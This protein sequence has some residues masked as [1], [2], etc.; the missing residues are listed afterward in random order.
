MA[1]FDG[2][3]VVVTGAGNGIGRALA[4]FKLAVIFEGIHYR[5]SQGNTVGVGFDRIGTAVAPLVAASLTAL[6]E[7]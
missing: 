3:G 5:F 6:K 7:N 2:L 1:D 4:Y